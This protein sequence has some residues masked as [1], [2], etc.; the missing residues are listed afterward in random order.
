M[1]QVEGAFDKLKGQEMVKRGS[2]IGVKR[3]KTDKIFLK[4]PIE[5]KT[6]KRGIS[7][8]VNPVIKCILISGAFVESYFDEI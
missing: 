2:L 8:E 1:R 3:R 6:L 4:R 5:L 7:E